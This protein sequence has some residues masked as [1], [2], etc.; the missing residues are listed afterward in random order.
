LF[1]LKAS[2]ATFSV[3]GE[4]ANHLP[5]FQKIEI[6]MFVINKMPTTPQAEK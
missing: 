6:L 3:L 5:D 1:W 2:K 4:F